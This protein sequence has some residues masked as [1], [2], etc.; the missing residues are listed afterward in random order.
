MLPTDVFESFI[1]RRIIKNSKNLFNRSKTLRLP[2]TIN[3]L[4][5]LTASQ[6]FSKLNYNLR[7]CYL[8]AFATF[9]RM[10]EVTYNKEDLK[11]KTAF[12]ETKVTRSYIYFSPNY[13]HATLLLKRSKTD[14]NNEGVTIL[15]SV[16]NTSFCLVQVLRDL[17]LY[18][19]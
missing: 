14:V 13:D 19:P 8:V 11:N 12:F 17:F 18:D 2:I 10:R 5:K 4:T 9:L 3:I 16:T 1:V 6:P 15:I 7:A